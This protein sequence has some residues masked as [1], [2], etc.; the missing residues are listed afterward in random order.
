MLVAVRSVYLVSTS[1]S[2][3]R[4]RSIKPPYV[5]GRHLASRDTAF[6]PCLLVADHEC[7]GRLLQ[8]SGILGRYV[9]GQ[10]AILTKILVRPSVLVVCSLAHD[11]EYWWHCI[12]E[13]AQI[14]RLWTGWDCFRP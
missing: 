2:G 13:N 8:L 14:G 12:G 4:V 7:Y 3:R 11:V 6:C 9:R 5:A 10:H 1:Q